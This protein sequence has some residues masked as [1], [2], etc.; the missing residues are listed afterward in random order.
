MNPSVRSI[1]ITRPG[2]PESLRLTE[3]APE[4]IERPDGVRIQVSACGVNFADIMMRMG[5]YPEAPPLPFVP[6][7]EVSGKVL[8]VGE[9]VRRFRPGDRVMAGC[10]FGGYSSEV[11]LPEFQVRKTPDGLSDIEAAAIPVN[12]ITA[13]VALEE[14]ARVRK[15][16]RV[17][18]QSAAG[19]VGIAALQ[20]ASNAGAEVTGLVS[21]PEKAKLIR[22]F[23]ANHAVLNEEWQNCSD[24]EAMRE[25]GYDTILDCEG[26]KSLRR[27]YRRLA[28]GGRVVTYGAATT[29]GGLKR[30]W[31][32]AIGFLLKTPIFHPLMLM[33]DT[34]GVFGVNLL[35]L[36]TPPASPERPGLLHQSFDRVVEQVEKGRLKPLIGATFPL[37]EAGAAHERLQSRANIGKIILIP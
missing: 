36:F 11:I 28:S 6:G 10:H 4:R 29:V 9:Q 37:S 15:G 31:L 20:I 12:F 8:E 13:W 32:R 22:E 23:G 26:G 24:Y 1:Q 33:K 5:L 14:L 21:T 30:S 34:K 2:G 19:G 18:V 17:L 3:S 25:G 27:N 35:Q 7:Y 16:D